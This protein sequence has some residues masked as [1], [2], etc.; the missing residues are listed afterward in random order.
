MPTNIL[1]VL[2]VD[3][4]ALRGRG[5][6]YNKFSRFFRSRADALASVQEGD[7]VP[8][9]GLTNAV[10]MLG[11]GI[12]VWSFDLQDFVNIGALSAADNQASRY[13]ELDGA[14]DY[15][16]LPTRSGGS[17]H[18]LDWSQD[19][20]IGITL[21]GLQPASDNAFMSLFRSGSNHITLRRG[22][23][24][25]GMYVTA[26]NNAYQHGAN[27][28]YAPTDTSRMLFTYDS[29]TYRLKYYLGEPSTGQYAMRANLA[30]NATV[31]GANAPGAGLEIGHGGVG[32]GAFE[33]IH[34]DGGVN[35][36]VVSDQVLVG[37]QIDEYF[38]TGEAFAEHEYYPDLTSYC[39]L[40]E[41]A[42]PAVVDSI[43]NITGGELVNGAADDF[44]DV[45]EVPEG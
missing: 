18:A 19:W 26:N 27:T 40:G 35:N 28:W 6:E 2:G 8:T 7:Y 21:L 12:M 38:Q 25:W 29:T 42:Y 3:T 5:V 9:P 39:R 17:E 30:V 37:P 11:E 1:G 14:N 31:R 22:G 45:P 36:L 15:I 24:N 13:I 10:L 20:S 41:D 34:W 23:S 33:I 43:G 16:S 44:R 32:S 4:L